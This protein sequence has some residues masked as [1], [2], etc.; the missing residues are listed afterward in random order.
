VASGDISNPNSIIN[1]TVDLTTINF[2]VF[3]KQDPIPIDGAKLILDNLNTGKNIVNLTTDINGKASLRWLNSFGINSN[4]SLKV[5]FYGQYWDFEIPELATGRVGMTNFSVDT[6]AA[7]TINI[8]FAPAELENLETKLVSLN[9]TDDIK[10]AWGSKIIIRALLNV[11]KVPSGPTYEDLLGP[12][13]ADSMVC[14]IYKGSTL[15]QSNMMPREDEYNG[16]HKVVIGTNGLESEAYI[17]RI[18]AQ[19]SGYVLPEDIIILLDL[20]ENELVLNQSQNDDS[21]QS[22]YWQELTDMSVKPYGKISEYTTFQYNIINMIYDTPFKFSIPDISND[23]NLTQI[24]FNIYNITWNALPNDI[25]ITIALNDYGIFETFDISNHDGYDYVLG[26]W[27]GIELNIDKSSPTNDNSFEFTIGGTFTGSIDIVADALFTRDK[28]NVQYSRFNISEIISLLAPSEGWAI[29][30]VTFDLY[31]CFNTSNWSPI[32]PL[33]DINMNFS[34]NEGIKYTLDSGGSGYGTLIIDDRLI[35]PLDGE[36][37]FTIENNPDVMFDVMIT[38]EYIQEFY[39]NNYLETT[40]I[41]KTEHNIGGTFQISIDDKMW[42]ENSVTLFINEISPDGETYFLPSE[43]AMTITIEGTPYYISDVIS[44]K[45]IFSLGNF[46]KDTIYQA[47][48]STNQYVSFN[49]E[50]KVNYSRSEFYDVEGIITYSIEDTAISGIV[51]HNDELDCYLQTINTALLD[52]KL[53]TIRFSVIKDNYVSAEK[54][55]NLDVLDRLTLINGSSLL[56]RKIENIYIEDAVNF[57]FLYS[58]MMTS[59]RITDLTTHYY[60]WEKYDI[61]GEVVID[62]GQGTLIPTVDDLYVLDFDTENLTIGVYSILVTIGKENYQTKNAWTTLTVKKRIFD[63]LLNDGN[64]QLQVKKGQTGI[65]RLELTDTTKGDIPLQNASAILT[66]MGDTYEFEEDEPGIY[67]LNLP[68]GNINTFFGPQTFTGIIN[69]TKENYISEELSFTLVVGMEEIFPG[70]P[71]FYFLL[72]VSSTLGIVVSI[73]A[74]R[75]IKHAR[76][77]T[78]VKKVREMKKTIAGDKDISNELLYRDKEAFIAE[79]VKNKWDKLGLSLEEIFGITIEKD[80]KEHKIKRKISGTIRTHDKK[81]LGLLFMK[82]DEKIGTEIL[83]KY[84]EDINITPKSLMQVYSTHEYSG[85]KGVITLI[86]ESLNILSYYTGPDKGYYLI[87]L[88]NL[89]D[90]PDVYEAGIADIAR[91]ILENIED[92]SYLRL[93][94]SLF[95][96]LS[97]YP[98]LSEEEI[99]IYHYQNG[100][101]RT[102]INILR[103]DGIISKSEL[104]IWLKDKY[105]ESFF[106]IESILTDLIKMEIIKVGSIKGLPSELIF[107]TNDLFTLRVPP[108]ILLDDPLN[109]GLPSQFVKEYQEAVKEFFQDYKP[110]EEDNIKITNLLINPQVYETLRLLRTAI[111]TRQDLEKLRKKGVYDINRVLKLL[112][113]NKMIKVFNDKMNNEYYALLTDIYVDLIFPKYV[114]SAVKTAYDQKSRVKKV[115]FEYLQILEDAYFELKKLE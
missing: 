74:Y 40:S 104:M 56:F 26:I 4:Y 20:S 103:D 10:V 33:S 58:D 71:F 41:S 79:I 87:L 32:N 13:Y 49:L 48:I 19:K 70:M 65:V 53:Y 63:P 84:P 67:I 8:H 105:T 111:V 28:I 94:P 115:L 36:F 75:A 57:T 24:T 107:F 2:T 86:T 50:F 60:I 7:Y 44:G 93:I 81:P 5:S 113:D 55:F 110:S 39:Q 16:R 30:N 82:W 109:R 99:L 101:K 38:V 14:H 83:V 43:L 76:I 15:I 29:R 25:N 73:V 72:I 96:R 95:Q 80:I 54:E 12:A 64:S 106:D 68:T 18:T 62:T 98:S 59:E 102:I 17:L 23:W 9:P 22:V 52:T 61:S 42:T 100:V 66:I 45:G 89:D 37:L 6:Q 21:A 34:T 51:Q 1:V 114:L 3:T 77:P 35:Y 31:N 112:W 46:D 27:T 47:F 108:T 88:L 97:V 11:T 85:D 91:I 90:D 69:I 78:F 92:E